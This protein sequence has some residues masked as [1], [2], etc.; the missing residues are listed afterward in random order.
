MK[1][2]Q[3]A[4]GVIALLL[5]FL[6][7]SS[8]ALLFWGY[9]GESGLGFFEGSLNYTLMKDS[10]LLEIQLT[11][12]SPASMGGYI[13]G[14]A[15]NNPLGYITGVTYSDTHF[16]LIGD[17]A[18]D[19]GINGMPMGYFDIGAAMGDDWMGGGD[20]KPGIG[21]GQTKLFSFNLT[22]TNLG[23][24]DETSFLN[25][26]SYG[27][28]PEMGDQFLG[29]RFRGFVN[30]GSDKVPAYPDPDPQTPE[31]TT[32]LLLGSGFLGFGAWN[33]IRH[34]KR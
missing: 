33:W 9:G 1:P 28:S 29:L 15:F 31:P 19:N 12:T 21:V 5:L 24:L 17:P 4:F 13:T 30:G 6:P 7:A 18:Y 10:A 11:N 2:I 25:A 8:S 16:K 14:L 23:L 32:V 20:P 22:G 3:K 34:R 27:G 26:L